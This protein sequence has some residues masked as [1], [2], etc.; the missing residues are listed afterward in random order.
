M[1]C[2]ITKYLVTIITKNNVKTRAACLVTMVKRS[3]VLFLL[4]E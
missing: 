4:N 1:L 2:M 3:I